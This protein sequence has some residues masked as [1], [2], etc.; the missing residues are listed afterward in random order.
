VPKLDRRK[1]N[2]TKTKTKT[3]TTKIKQGSP[4]DGEKQYAQ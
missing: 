1:K 2:G 3:A 4:A